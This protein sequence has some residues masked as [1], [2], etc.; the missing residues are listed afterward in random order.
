MKKNILLLGTAALL[1]QSAFAA[2][3]TKSWVNPCVGGNCEVKSMKIYI[4]KEKSPTM[5]GNMVVAEMGVSSIDAVKK[6]AFVQYIKGCTYQS[7]AA[8]KTQ[9]TVRQYFGKQGVPFIHKDFEIDTGPDK[10]PIYG[11]NQYAGYDEF[12]GYE[13]PRHS[14]YYANNPL[15]PAPLRNWSGREDKLFEPKLWVDDNPSPSI[16]TGS[17]AINSSLNFKI[18]IYEI[19]KLPK[20]ETAPGTIYPEPVN[21]MEWDSNYI[22]NFQKKVFE[23]K[24]GI[25]SVCK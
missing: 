17:G 15:L 11:S 9:L 22:Y 13:I 23:E 18:C 6:Y 3:T 25:S 2:Y 24:V 21:C 4:T 7:N 16:V 5:A 10:D 1:T 14:G 20:K 8:G 12:R 19:S